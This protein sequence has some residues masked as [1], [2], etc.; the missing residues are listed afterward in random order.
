MTVPR[1]LLALSLGVGLWTGPACAGR[2][3][4]RDDRSPALSV[5]SFP[6]GASVYV[7]GADSG[8]TL[9]A[10][11]TTALYYDYSTTPYKLQRLTLAT[12]AITTLATNAQASWSEGGRFLILTQANGD[13]TI[14]TPDGESLQ[15][16]PAPLSYT[17]SPQGT[18]FAFRSGPDHK[19]FAGRLGGATLLFSDSVDRILWRDDGRFYYVRS[20]FAVPRGFLNG[21]YDARVP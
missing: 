5:E 12:G 9:S 17:L 21:L 16:L 20:G 8:L 11:R 18:H 14:A 10:D 7:G 4:E 19:L 6:S 13:I 2:G 15:V 1:F 3:A